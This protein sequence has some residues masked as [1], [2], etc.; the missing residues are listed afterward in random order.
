MPFCVQ[1]IILAMRAHPQSA[2]V[3]QN[4]CWVLGNLS[5]QRTCS[6]C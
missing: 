3:Q 1:S 5:V 4:A 2:I 6:S